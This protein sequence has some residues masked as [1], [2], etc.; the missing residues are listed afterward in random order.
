MTKKVS[1]LMVLAVGMLLLSGCISSYFRDYGQVESRTMATP[2]AYTKL[3][4]S[5]AFTVEMRPDITEPIITMPEGLFDKLIFR[6]G[7]GTLEIGLRQWNLGNV[8]ELMVE[9]PMNADLTSIKES[10]ASSMTVYGLTK[11]QRVRLSGASSL[12]VSGSTEE[13]QIDL[14]GASN[15]DARD[16]LAD[17]IKGQ[18]SGASD[19]DVTVCHELKVDLSGA[20]HLSYGLISPTCNPV[21]NCPASGA[22]TVIRR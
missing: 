21:I 20:S 17:G 11:L 13:L 16:L 3:D 22:S 2:G 6:V 14:S 18:L 15:L 4:I 8:R 19:A 5:H 12:L 9:L 7:N 1:I 10:G